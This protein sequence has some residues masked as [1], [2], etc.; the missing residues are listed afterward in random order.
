[1][2]LRLV[3]KGA[4]KD[5][6]L[7]VTGAEVTMY[8]LR[9]ATDADYEFLYALHVAAMQTYITATW[10]WNETWQR[11]Y[12]EK[13]WNPIKQRIIQVAGEDAGVL[14]TGWRPE[15]F[16]L[17]LIELLPQYQGC[18]V[19][20]AVIHDLQAMAA[21][22]GYDIYLHVLKSN[23]PARRLYERLDFRMIEER[24]ERFVMIWEPTH[25]KNV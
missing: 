1:M 23:Q 11:E 24:E 16:F 3:D 10:G 13:K 9:Q 22:Q 18:G 21:K 14:V 8:S 4:S 12:F 19:G 7:L 6:P 25:K 2:P 5:L 15:G 20:T 17:E